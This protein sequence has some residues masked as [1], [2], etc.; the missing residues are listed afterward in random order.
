MY[1]ARL[2]TCSGR[3]LL[4]GAA[5]RAATSSSHALHIASFINP[6]SP[7]PLT[8]RWL[9]LYSF[10]P[11]RSPS[12]CC[13]SGIQDILVMPA[14]SCSGLTASIWNC[15]RDPEPP[16]V[17]QRVQAFQPEHA[18]PRC[19]P[20]QGPKASG[21]G[22]GRWDLVFW[23]A[24]CRK[25]PSILGPRVLRLVLVLPAPYCL[26]LDMRVYNVLQLT[27]TLRSSHDCP[28]QQYQLWI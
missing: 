25:V 13:L 17:V 10:R 27:L 11:R 9:Y 14:S 26:Q 22:T 21:L 15:R 8:T 28:N 7:S 24:R 18:L 4:R 6:Q 23:K 20:D 1:S 5:C 19:G 3:S 16:V 12:L 2:V